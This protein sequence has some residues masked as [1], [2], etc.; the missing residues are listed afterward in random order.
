VELQKLADDTDLTLN[1]HHYPPGTSKW[2]E[3]RLI[4]HITQNWRWRPLTS[5]VAVVE[6]I[7]ATTTK[8]GLTVESALDERTDVKGRKVKQAEMAASTS[9]VIRS[10]LSG[11]GSD[12]TGRHCRQPLQ[13]NSRE[14]T[15]SQLRNLAARSISAILDRS[16]SVTC[17]CGCVGPLCPNALRSRLV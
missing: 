16:S 7:A 17:R 11:T 6:L 10:I 8:T 4:C 3:H 1:V 9:P 14:R 15:S 2:K 13:Y 5:R 12:S